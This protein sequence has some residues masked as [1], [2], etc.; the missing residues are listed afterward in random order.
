M[1]SIASNFISVAIAVIMGI[2]Q[3]ALVTVFTVGACSTVY[4][5]CVFNL[6]T[7]EFCILIYATS[8]LIFFSFTMLVGIKHTLFIFEREVK[9]FWQ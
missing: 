4:V 8:M 1:L 6:N 3:C 5:M 7:V 9:E 2:V